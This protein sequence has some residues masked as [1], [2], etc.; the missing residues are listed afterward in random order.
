MSVGGGGISY[1]D[2]LRAAQAESLRSEQ[3]GACRNRVTLSLPRTHDKNKRVIRD[4]L[5][6]CGREPGRLLQIGSGVESG[7]AT[8]S[9]GADGLAIN[10]IDAVA[11]G[12]NSRS[13]GSGAGTFHPDISGLITIYHTIKESGGGSVSNGDKNPICRNNFRRFVF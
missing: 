9:G 2:T 11:G 7:A 6:T 4:L 5:R 12:E 3:P 10:T 8:H 13:A 1:Y